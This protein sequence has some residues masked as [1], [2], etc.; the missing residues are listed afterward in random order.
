MPAPDPFG[1]DLGFSGPLSLLVEV[2]QCGNKRHRKARAVRILINLKRG[3][4]CCP[5][6]GD[7]V[8]LYRRADA[9]YCRTGC[10]KKAARRRKADWPLSTIRE[11]QARP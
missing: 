8:P 6:C 10:R 11:G 2:W 4:W 7:Y 3:Q 1:I 9:V 5:E